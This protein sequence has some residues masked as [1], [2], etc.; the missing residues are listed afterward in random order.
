MSPDE[1]L[2]YL[3]AL[4]AIP[5]S[6]ERHCWDLVQRIRR[7]LFSSD[8]LPPFGADLLDRPE[9]RQS[10]FATHPA[11]AEWREVTEP[12]DGDV[13]I[14]TKPHDLHAGIYL[15]DG[16]RGRIWHTDI[17]HGLVADT[18]FEVT[19]LRR[20]KLRFYRRNP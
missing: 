19:Q 4:G 16:G 15:T 6:R 17:G 9:R 12:Q 18:P 8:D 7:D 5:W 20:W 2:A 3:N 13:A 14:M 1:R 10:V 11:R